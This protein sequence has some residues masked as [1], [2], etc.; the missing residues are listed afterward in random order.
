[1]QMWLSYLFE[2]LCARGANFN[3]TIDNQAAPQILFASATSD[4]FGAILM[5]NNYDGND[6]QCPPNNS[7]N[8]VKHKKITGSK[9]NFVTQKC[10]KMPQNGYQLSSEST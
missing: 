1:M 3:T 2:V 6:Y 10:I 4:K 8:F 7:I 5:S 9:R